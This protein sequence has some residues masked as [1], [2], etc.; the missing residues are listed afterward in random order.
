MDLCPWR[1]MSA[2][3]CTEAFRLAR[4]VFGGCWWHAPRLRRTDQQCPLCPVELAPLSLAQA[5]VN[6]AAGHLGWRDCK[7]LPVRRVG[8]S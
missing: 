3:R 6:L 4:R 8:V 7:P 5:T 2:H 1:H